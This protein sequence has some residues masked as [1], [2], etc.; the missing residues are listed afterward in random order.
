[1]NIAFITCFQKT[2]IFYEISKKLDEHKT[3]WISTSQKYINKLME[4]G[5]CKDDILYLNLQDSR[6]FEISEKD[7]EYIKALEYKNG[8][9]LNAV[10][11]MDRIISNWSYEDA[12]KYFNYV[13]C[14]TR[15]F[16]I[17]NDIQIVTSETTAA[18]E[19]LISLLCKFENRIY[20]AP[21]TIRMPSTKFAFFEGIDY[22]KVLPVRNN[23]SDE[24]NY[25]ICDEVYKIVNVTKER[26]FYW[27]KGNEIP[28]YNFSYIKKCIN[29]IKEGQNESKT[30]ASVKSLKHQI[31]IEKKYL[32]PIRARKLHSNNF[33]KTPDYKNEK[34]VLITLHKQPEAS[35]DVVG[36]RYSNQIE[37]IRRIARF[38]P[39][40]FKIYVKEHSLA[41]GERNGDY[42]EQMA[43]IPGVIMIDPY[44]DTLELM[45]KAELVITVT[46]TVAYEA[47]IKGIKA[48]TLSDMY[49]S[50]LSTVNYIESEKDVMKILQ[51]EKNHN[52]EADKKYITEQLL[53]YSF[54]GLVGD[55]LN[56]P[57][58]IAPQNIENMAIAFKKLIS[59]TE[60]K[61]NE[62]R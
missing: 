33:F 55:A 60:E 41:F 4:H 19:V 17:K 20:A 26:P 54:D 10:Y 44:L 27:A 32:K 50:K 7:R 62:K 6:N 51:E 29:K 3:F 47:G 42:L 48:V 16:I 40:N 49:F 21:Q 24:E 43:K 52:I 1:M 12:I 39:S 35:I 14:K 28:K 45:N 8:L 57:E 59:H 23:L 25:K 31:F 30:D 61:K 9:S 15:D 53:R 13:I 37:T 36:Y 18:H 5:V 38:I 22:S 58:S 56:S 46:G 2:P 11:Y 34:Y